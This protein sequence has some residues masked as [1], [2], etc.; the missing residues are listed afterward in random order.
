MIGLGVFHAWSLFV[1]P[2]ETR[3][4][5]S[6][7]VV[8]GVYAVAVGAFTVSMLL[9]PGLYRRSSPAAIATGARCSPQLACGWPGRPRVGAMA[10][11]TRAYSASPTAQS[12]EWRQRCQ[13]T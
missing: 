9:A 7:A 12:V 5:L 1:T 8:S 10:G 13:L 2:L 11:A 4:D 3:L 6:R